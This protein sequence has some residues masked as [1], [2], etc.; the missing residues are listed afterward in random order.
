MNKKSSIK[1]VATT[2]TAPITTPVI[3][4]LKTGTCP[5]LSGSAKLGYH[6]G[7]TP[8]SSIQMRVY[9]NSGTGYFS[10]EWVSLDAVFK[11]L[12]KCPK[13]KPL[14]AFWLVPMYVGKSTQILPR[15]KH[16]CRSA[17]CCAMALEIARQVGL[18]PS[19]N[20]RGTIS[21]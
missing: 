6:I 16:R 12:D 19:T 7:C 8:D 21:V 14:N 3:R 11:A 1:S 20:G 13:D 18:L 9:T 2:T 5:N 4:I 10:K 15:G 17:T